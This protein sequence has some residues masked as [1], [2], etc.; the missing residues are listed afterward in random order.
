MIAHN[1]TMQALLSEVEII[2]RS[3]CPVLIVG[4][5][6]TGKEVLADYI[7]SISPRSNQKFVKVS[8]SSLPHTLVESELFGHEKGAFTGADRAREGFFESASNATI[9]LDDIDDFPLSLQ[10]K[11]LRVIENK[12]LIRIGSNNSIRS[13]VRIISSSK[14][15]LSDMADKGNFRTDLYYRLSVFKLYIPPLRDRKDEI[16]SLLNHFINI[17]KPFETKRLD[18]GRLNLQPLYDYNWKGNI[19]ELRNFAEKLM[20][21]PE[22]EVYSNFEQIFRNYT[23]GRLNKESINSLQDAE[24]KQEVRESLDSAVMKYEEELIRNTLRQSFGNI[25]LASRL[26]K[27]K[28][29]TLRYKI[30]NYNIDTKVYK[31]V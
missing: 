16:P 6:G 3:D 1:K 9:F 20:L 22:E 2:R 27:I 14:V 28:P 12:E 17:E 8:L 29:S 11:L 26:L 24:T 31:K 25:S 30:N 10:T 13:D 18:I 7:H 5:T 15:E 19:R 23:Y 21:Y 4:E